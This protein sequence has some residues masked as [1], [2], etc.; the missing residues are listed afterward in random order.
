MRHT[1]P[2][3]PDPVPVAALV[4]TLGGQAFVLPLPGQ[5]PGLLEVGTL[6]GLPVWAAEGSRREALHHAR[7]LARS[8]APGI[9][10]VD[11][12]ALRLRFAAITLQ[13]VRVVPLSLDEAEPLPLRRL[14]QSLQRPSASDLERALLLADALDVDAAGRQT[15]RLLHR[16]LARMGGALPSRAPVMDRHGWALIQLTRL[17]FL[18]FVEAEGWLDGNRAFL[19]RAFDDCLHARRDPGRHLLQPLFFGTLNRPTSERSRLA[20]SFGRIPFLNGGLFEPHALERRYQWQLP[21]G[22]WQDA[23]EALVDR[24]EVTLDADPLQGQV[25]PELLGRVFEGTMDPDARHGDGAYFTPPALVRAI[26]RAAVVSHLSHQDR[27]GEQQIDRALADPGPAL[28]RRLLNLRVLDPAVGS[29]EFLV[30]ALELLH[31]PGPRRLDR[32]RHLVTRRL[33]GV[34]RHPGAVRICELRLWLEVLR[35]MRGK[36]SAQVAPLPN[37]DSTIRA[38]DSLLDPLAGRLSSGFRSAVLTRSHHALERSHG[39]GKRAVIRGIR[40]E[41]RAALEARLTERIMECEAA[42]GELLAAHRGPTLFRQR[43]PLGRAARVRLQALRRHRSGLRRLAR[44]LRR[45]ESASPFAL[46]LAFAPLLDGRSGF[47]LVLG[48]P[49]WVRAEQL[50]R[51]AREALAERFRWWRSG[52]GRHWRH[53]PDLSVAF[54]ERATELLNENGTLALLLPGKLATTGY[55]ERCR[56]ELTRRHTIH[57]VADLSDDPRADFEATTY[58]LALVL[59][60]GAPSADHQARLGLPLDAPRCRQGEWASSARW[61]LVPEGVQQLARRLAARFPP[62]A[63]SLTPQLGIKTGAND[64]YLDPP[65]ALSEWTRPAIRGRSVRPFRILRH[66]PLLWPAD[67]TGTPWPQ[68]PEIVATFLA[69]H[70]SRLKARADLQD[71]RWWRL[72]RTASAAQRHRVIWRDLAPRL[73]AAVLEDPEAV[74]LNSCYVA[75]VPSRAGAHALTAWLN[76][77]PVRALVRMTAEPA[78]GGCA[79]FGGRAVGS[80]PF[81]PSLLS[82]AEFA[83]L[84]ERASHGEPVQETIDALAAS[85]LELSGGEVASLVALAASRR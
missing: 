25:T 53:A 48:N 47:D 85:R 54:L 24:I 43:S 67:R 15:F 50:A 57:C 26:V 33:F 12:R 83:E 77:S 68:L 56:A 58:P 65:A 28:R 45:D 9:L 52:T 2:R 44:K 8:R 18:R 20:R 31:G 63:D 17:L 40:R 61:D 22:V 35:A 62:L 21:T 84:G 76:A 16:L 34:D 41:E 38:G 71:T 10:F 5:E 7:R 23:F 82:D 36:S 80:A 42:I 13:P 81:P 66:T 70:A 29:G 72:F 69:P 14:A 3:G 75:G 32:V 37:L 74:P 64:V 55:A 19:A 30:G 46:E 59:S 60:C 79:R 78:A 1:L 51:D 39:A 11:D 73:E 49:P 4:H 27:A 6:A